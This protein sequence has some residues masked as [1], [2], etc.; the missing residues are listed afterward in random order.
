VSLQWS[1]SGAARS[2]N[3]KEHGASLAAWSS[4]KAGEEAKVWLFEIGRIGCSMIRA[5]IKFW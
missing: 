4:F 1:A 3:G 2:R 5:G